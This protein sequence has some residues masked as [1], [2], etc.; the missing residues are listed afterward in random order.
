M[1][2]LIALTIFLFACTSHAQT[3]EEERNFGSENATNKLRIISSTDTAF[4]APIIKDFLVNQP[5]VQIEYLVHGTS[6]IDEIYRRSPES[7]DLVISSAMDLQLKLVNDNL[8]LRLPLTNLPKWAKWRESL[9]A[10]TTEPATIVINVSAFKGHKLPKTRQDL[11]V[12]LRERPDVF[13]N[14]LA[15]YDV[16]K[17]GL[18]YLFATQ[19][20]RTTETYW[21]LMEVM[22]GVG[23]K[24][25]C[26]SGAMINDLISGDVV[27]A[28]N[29][30]GSYASAR[31]ANNDSIKV[32]LPSD[33]PT[34]MMRTALISQQTQEPDLAAAFIRHLIKSQSNLGKGL[35]R[36]PPLATKNHQST[37]ELKPSL[38]TYLDAL[39]RRAFIAAWESAVIQ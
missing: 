10:F 4:V 20:A 32:I 39:K 6:T 28:Y 15:T 18:G 27:V 23:T 11:I 37:I 33:F 31:Q 9:F 30:L 21:R 26:C 24:L 5:T 34:T 35:N 25:Y 36:L 29:V 8:A 17:S 3:W 16:R 22:G 38:L 12:A 19:D 14:K 2:Y 1:R 13:K 7:Y